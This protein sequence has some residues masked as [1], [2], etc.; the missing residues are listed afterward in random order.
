MRPE[1]VEDLLRSTN[2]LRFR[3]AATGGFVHEERR[4]RFVNIDDHGI[5]ANG[6]ERRGITAVEGAVWAF[7]GSTTFGSGVA[8]HETIPAQLERLIGRPVINFAVRGDG[9]LMENRLLSYYLRVGYRP[10]LAMFLDGINE[11]CRSDV[12]GSELSELVARS[13]VGY[14]WTFGLPVTYAYDAVRRRARQFAGATDPPDHL[15][16]TCTDDGAQN[17][18]R[19]IHARILAERASLCA[20]YKISCRTFV[21]PFA[22]LHGRH[23]DRA[24]AASANATHLRALF[25]E[26]EGGWRAHGATFITSALDQSDRHHFIDEI[27]YSA[28]ASGLIAGAIALTIAPAGTR[29]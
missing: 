23:D 11:A 2:T 3:F 13:Q 6:P 16:L 24:F 29:Q 21:Q 1:D 19:V 14:Q 22:T 26:L 8:D 18:L 20:L 27:H 28:H 9:S 7:G 25:T 17:P 10:A 5:R 12:F 4:T 15:E